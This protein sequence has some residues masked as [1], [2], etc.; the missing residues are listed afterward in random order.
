MSAQDYNEPATLLA[1]GRDDLILPGQKRTTTLAEAV[2]TVI[3]EWTGEQL[4]DVFIA[5]SSEA[6]SGLEAVRAIYDHKDFP[7]RRHAPDRPLPV[8]ATAVD[9]AHVP[10][11]ALGVRGTAS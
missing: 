3:E 11:E 1:Y 6:I 2:R 7:L 10:I 8:N 9:A 5:S 4:I